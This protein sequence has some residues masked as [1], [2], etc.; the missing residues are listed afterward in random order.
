MKWSF[1]IG[2]FAGIDVYMHFTFILLVSWVA[3]VHWRQGQSLSAALAGVLFI[4]VV[5]TCVVL[6]EFGHALMARRYGI[7][8]RDI[9]LLPIGGV[10]MLASLPEKPRQELVIAAAGPAVNVVIAGLLWTIA[11]LSPQL[12]ILDGHGLVEARCRHHPSAP[13]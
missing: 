10:A 5:F 13:F 1:K 4:L 2:R 11:G 9:I 3:M 8:T 7:K 6:H 12:G